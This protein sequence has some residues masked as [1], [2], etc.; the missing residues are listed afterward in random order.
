[1]G[2]DLKPTNSKDK[3]AT[4]RLD[5]SL[6]PDTAAAYGAL[7]MVEGD[8]KYGGYNY[9]PGGVLASV[10]VAAC[11]RHLSKWYNGQDEDAKTKV[12][13]LASALACIAVM[14]DA[15]E[16]GVLQDD[17]PPACDLDGLL[18]RCEEKVKHLQKTFPNGPR[19]YTQKEHP[20]IKK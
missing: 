7:A 20:N 1:M 2:E 16:C 9:R 12:H 4:S 5:L 17:R 6:F 8:C 3:A 10:Y 18:A 15:I 11:R 13:H 14:I 19:R